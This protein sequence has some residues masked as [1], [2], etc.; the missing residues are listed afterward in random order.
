VCGD[1]TQIMERADTI[2]LFVFEI[3]CVWSCG[4]YFIHRHFFFWDRHSTFLYA[5]F[6]HLTLQ[7]ELDKV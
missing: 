2:Q 4:A 1:F 6:G 5:R 7:N 3:V